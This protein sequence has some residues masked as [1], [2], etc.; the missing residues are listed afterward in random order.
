MCTWQ[1]SQPPRFN[2]G[3][4]IRFVDELWV[5][6]RAEPIEIKWEDYLDNIGVPTLVATAATI[7]P[8]Y[9]APAR[10]KAPLVFIGLVAGCF[11]LSRR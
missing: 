8:V 4:T 10:W 11:L 6:T 5:V 2:P 1:M 7:T 3:D 9:V